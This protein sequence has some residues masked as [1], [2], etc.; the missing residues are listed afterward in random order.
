MGF[1]R[2]T[3]NKGHAAGAHILQFSFKR[4]RARAADGPRSATRSFRQVGHGSWPRHWDPNPKTIPAAEYGR[5]LMK[6][7]KPV[8]LRITPFIAAGAAVIA[9]VM[10]FLVTAHAGTEPG[11][12]RSG[13]G[14]HV[15][16]HR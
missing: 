16:T 15:R 3:P 6:T 4:R 5:R 13:P 8:G 7:L 11:S 10:G 9:V 2:N 14:V 12:R 1:T